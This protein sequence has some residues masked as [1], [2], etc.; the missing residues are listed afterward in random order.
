MCNVVDFVQLYITVAEVIWANLVRRTT[1]RAYYKIS[2]ENNHTL[3]RYTTTTTM[4]N[5][6]GGYYNIPILLR[7]T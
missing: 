2:I 6:G 4:N 7:T 1:N 5:R 3:K